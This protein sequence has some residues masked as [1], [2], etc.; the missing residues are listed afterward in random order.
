MTHG[1]GDPKKP[2]SDDAVRRTVADFLKGDEIFRGKKVLA[3]VPD[4][5]RSCPLPLLFESLVEEL[6]GKTARLSFLV[7]IG[8][9]A[10]PPEEELLRPFGL[11][12]ETKKRN[13]SD[14]DILPHRWNDPATFKKVGTFSADRIAGLT[15]GLF[16]L[17]VNVAVNKLIF[18]YDVILIVGPVFPHEVVGFSGG[19]KYIFPGVGE[20]EFINFFHWLGAV[21][22]NPKI[23]GNRDTPVRRLVEAA[24]EFIEI[25]RRAICLVVKDPDVYGVFAGEVLPA[26]REACALSGLVNVVTKPRPFKSVLAHMPRMYKDI[27]LAGKG[28]YKLENVVEDGGELI[29]YAPHITEI[30]YSHG[31]VLE[32]VGYHVRDYFLKQWDRFKHH[33]WGVLAHS[34]HVRGIGVYENGIEKPRVKVTLATGIPE[35]KCRSVNLGYRDPASI[36]ITEWRGREEE[37]IL[38]VPHAGEVLYR[39]ENPPSWAS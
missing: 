10:V 37:G 36:N 21:I 12:P 28:M 18:D 14:I 20:K 11:D 15:D 33:P 32:L 35:K 31:D 30:S 25:P 9:H 17:E 5:T 26:W 29:I 22:T 39:L 16:S 8:T 1:L 6:R 13:Y 2:L 34:T 23:I 24:A 19:H 7:A 3:L 38:Y 27:W 4:E